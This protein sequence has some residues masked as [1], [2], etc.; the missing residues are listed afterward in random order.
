MKIRTLSRGLCL[1]G[2]LLVTACKTVDSSGTPANTYSSTSEGSELE[3]VLGDPNLARELVI[4][5]LRTER[6]DGRLFAQFNLRNT[7]RENLAFEWTIAWTDGS[8]FFL[9]TPR[10]WTPAS[11]GG[12]AF[13]TISRTAPTAE[14]TGFRMGFRRPNTIR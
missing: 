14:A 11:L 5:S 6:R 2:L 4:E 8:G 12:G 13:Q 7:R 3:E 1:A 10:T 9:D